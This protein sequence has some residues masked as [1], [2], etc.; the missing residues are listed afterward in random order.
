M[1]FLFD[2][3]MNFIF[4]GLAGVASLVFAYYLFPEHTTLV[5]V[6]FGVLTVALG[7]HFAFRRRSAT[8]NPKD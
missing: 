4:F 2:F 8:T 5:V 6:G 7:L 1:R 3:V